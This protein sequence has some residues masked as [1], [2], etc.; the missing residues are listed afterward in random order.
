MWKSRQHKFSVAGAWI[1]SGCK[2]A[3]MHDDTDNINYALDGFLK[4]SNCQLS[5]YMII[6]N[7]GT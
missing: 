6:C 7:A 5:S 3:K 1:A 4:E 2:L